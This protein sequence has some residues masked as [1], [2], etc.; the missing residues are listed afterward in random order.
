M[1][2]GQLYHNPYRYAGISHGNYEM[3]NGYYEMNNGFYG[4]NNGYQGMNGYYGMNND[5]DFDAYIGGMQ[6]IKSIRNL[7]NI[8]IV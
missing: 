8:L 4:I 3:D 1:S 7:V 5:N 2:Q 6:L